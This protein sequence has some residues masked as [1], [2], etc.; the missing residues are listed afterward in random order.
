MSC[1]T[2]TGI[3]AQQ[4][5]QWVLGIFSFLESI[6][7]AVAQVFQQWQQQWQNVCNQ[8]TSSIQAWQQQW[9]NQCSQV[10][11]Q[12]CN[13]LPWPLSALCGWVTST[14]CNLVSV[15]VQV[16]VVI[17]QTVCTLVSVLISI[18]TLVWQLLCTLVMLIIDVLIL[19]VYVVLVAVLVVVCLVTPCR[20]P[21]ESS[22]PPDDG[23]MVT[24]GQSKPPKLSMNNTV[25]VLPDG[26]LACEQIIS[27]IGQATTTIHIIQLEFD[28][29]FITTF[30]GVNP[31]T[32]LVCALLRA[33]TKMSPTGQPLHVR[34]L[35]NNNF[36]ASSSLS[37]LQTAFAGVAN[38]EVAG[39]DIQPLKHLGVVH[40]KG[41][42][43]DSSVAFVDGLPFT[44]GYWDTQSHFV[45][46]PRRGSGAA[47]DAALA[48]LNVLGNVGNGV[49]NKP[50]HTVSIQ[51]TGPAAA[52]VDA[53]FVSLWNSVSSDQVTVAPPAPGLGQQSIQIVRTA[54]RLADVGF[55]NE[56][57]VLEAYLRAINNART[58]IYIEIQYLTSPV[59]GQALTRALTA[60]PTLQLILLLNENPDMPTYKFW[61]N[62]LLGQLS[63]FSSQIGVF[64]P[65]RTTPPAPPQLT[66][67]MQ[68]YMEAK[69]S[70]VDDAWATVGTANLDGASLGHIFE[71]LP[72]PLSCLS[73]SRGWRNV[74]L[75]AVL[76]DGIAGQPA[77]G[78]VA[79]LRQTL[80]EEHL[81]LT[82]LPATPPPGG[83]LALWNQVAAQN[84]AALNAA[85]SM[86]GPL[87]MP[88]RILPY[89]SAL[90]SVD[91]LNQLSVNT[92]LLNVAPVVP[93]P[94]NSDFV[95][96][97]CDRQEF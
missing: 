7:T 86:P 61:Q 11:S 83:W 27:A 54:P 42:F 40:A 69:A 94:T 38:I 46:D 8:V 44:Q 34:I 92:G 25:S 64:C 9:Q 19:V 39:L 77:T 74:E 73:A 89:A 49:G 6:C 17:V 62:Q 29:D 52:D 87:N 76:Y 45:S 55:S 32:S 68:C 30:R 93:A 75:N 20:S 53:T 90:Q 79:Q 16:I 18:I 2:T 85:Q 41:M 10:T 36:F 81:G 88:S 80:W 48:G 91:Q 71:F 5:W 15:L 58:F 12:V 70:V 66:E 96:P 4:L 37:E 72:P 1:F 51:L 43:I 84:L 23:W 59:I 31:R 28:S 97:P 24:L 78:Q 65:W 26:E 67:I 21:M 56:K 60:R 50:A 47:G 95:P 57:G 33:S 22:L 63:A 13:S 3:I 35:V 14:V 82:S